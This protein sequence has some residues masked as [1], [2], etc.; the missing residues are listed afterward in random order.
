MVKYYIDLDDTGFR[1]I[2][3]YGDKYDSIGM[4][5]PSTFILTNYGAHSKNL[6]KFVTDNYKN[7]DQ[8]GSAIEYK[9]I[10][11]IIFEKGKF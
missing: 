7:F 8:T 2:H 6:A 9:K 10:I 4:S 5:Y 1:F 3:V 11:C